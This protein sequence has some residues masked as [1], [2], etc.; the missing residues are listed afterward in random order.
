MASDDW[1]PARDS[2]FEHDSDLCY[3]DPWY[4]YARELYNPYWYDDMD[5]DEYDYLVISTREYYRAFYGVCTFCGQNHPE[6]QPDL[7][8]YSFLTAR[9][10]EIRQLAES[11][12]R[13]LDFW[14]R[15]D[16]KRIGSILKERV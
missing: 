7:F 5:P 10:R 16:L 3:F 6:Y 12:V 14:G 9:V 8:E 15:I 1:Q 11:A 2:Y 4:G 13:E